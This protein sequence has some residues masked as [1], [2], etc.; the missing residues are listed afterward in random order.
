M[1][2][3]FKNLAAILSVLLVTFSCDKNPD[4]VIY[5]LDPD[6]IHGVIL[7]T[8]SI[9]NFLLNSSDNNSAFMVTVEEQD[10]QDG[11]LMESVDV[12]VSFRDFTPDN[13]TTPSNESF[14]KN[15]PASAFSTGPLGL[16]RASLSV[17]F[18]EATSA[19]GLSPDDYAPGDIYVI[20]FRVNTTD[21]RVFGASSSSNVLTGVYF[22]SPFKYNAPLTCSPVPGV[23]TVEMEDSYGDGWQ[24]N[25]GN[26]GDGIQVTLNGTDVLQVGMCSAYA[27]PLW[28]SGTEC[29]DN[30]DG[31]GPV[32]GSITIPVGTETASWNFPG[33]Q[34][35]EIRFKIF[36]PDGAL[37]FDSGDYGDT[38]AGLIPVVN[39]L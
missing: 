1:K 9:D 10:E 35:G 8:V 7:R 15:V 11:A 27:T 31:Y 20:E 12:Y 29:T 2:Y 19:M 5:E 17:T 21:G 24:T 25:D 22:K 28:L 39:C 26:S 14:I 6:A 38:G 37:L 18:G 30:G 34:Y 16:P 23:Y 3:I 32:T 13:G 33:D 4:N 36:G